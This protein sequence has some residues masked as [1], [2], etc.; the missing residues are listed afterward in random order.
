MVCLDE[1]KGRGYTEG[2]EDGLMN[3]ILIIFREEGE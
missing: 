2:D 3:L 1:G